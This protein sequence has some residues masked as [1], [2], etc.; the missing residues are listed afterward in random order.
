MSKNELHYLTATEITTLYTQKKLSPVEVTEAYLNR[1]EAMNDDLGAYIT[2]DYAGAREAAKLAEDAYVLDRVHSPLTGVPIGLKDIIH[3]KDMRTTSGSRVTAD[4]VADEDSTI[5]ERLRA[6]GA[7]ILGK[8]NL[9]EFAIGG[10]I[11]HPFGT[12][13]NPWNTRHATGGSSSGSA[14]AVA[15]GLC[16]VALGSDTG[17]SIRGPASFCGIAGIRP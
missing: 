7:V 13:R 3:I 2:V 17:G 16:A 1:I 11:D 5:V 6:A 8:L 14:V 4:Y 9:S 15:A 10:T 12:P